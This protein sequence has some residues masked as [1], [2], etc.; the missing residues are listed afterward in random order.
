M[1][2]PSNCDKCINHVKEEKKLISKRNKLYNT[3]YTYMCVC[4][5]G[6]YLILIIYR[7]KNKRPVH[8]LYTQF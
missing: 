8:I 7:R 2:R 3:M 1:R 5:Y 4:T 6:H